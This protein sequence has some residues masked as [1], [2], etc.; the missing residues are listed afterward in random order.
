MGRIPDF[1]IWKKGALRG[2]QNTSADQPQD[3]GAGA[4][5]S[6]DPSERTGVRALVAQMAPALTGGARTNR[7]VSVVAQPVAPPPVMPSGTMPAASPPSVTLPVNPTVAVTEQPDAPPVSLPDVADTSKPSASGAYLTRSEAG[8]APQMAGTRPALQHNPADASQNDAIKDYLSAVSAARLRPEKQD[9][10]SGDRATDLRDRRDALEGYQPQKRSWWD[11]LKAA[12]P[13]SLFAAARTGNPLAAAG[14]LLGGVT[15]GTA[16]RKLADQTWRNRQLAE[17]GAQLQQ[18]YADEQQQSRTRLVDAQADLAEARPGMEQAKADVQAR[19]RAQAAIQREI[20]NR[21]KEPRPFDQNDVYDSSLAQRAQAA[22]VSFDP[23]GFGDT[24]NP[25]T[26]EML[27]PTDPSGTRKTRAVYDRASNTWKPLAVDGQPIATGYAQPVGPDGMTA[28]QRGN[29][30]LG[31]ERL[32]ESKHH[33]QV[34]EGQ[35]AERIGI[36][37]QNFQLG[38]A[39][40]EQGEARLAQ[41]AD[42]QTRT[43]YN[44]LST[45]VQQRNDAQAQA[46]RWRSYKGDD[47]GVQPWAEKRA[48]VFE[49]KIRS[50]EDRM[51]SHYGDLLDEAATSDDGMINGQQKA[52]ENKGL[53]R[54]PKPPARAPQSAPAPAQP[55]G[56][57]SRARFR[58][59]YPQYQSAPDSQVD[60]II[61]GQGYQPKP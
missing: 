3:D 49:D 12:L 8:Q 11:N 41:G 15:V 30:Q 34:T 44:Q 27:D 58:A 33:N 54:T 2:A 36:A 21:L 1:L 48:G 24:K 37:R 45:L 39:R 52:M 56:S 53:M 6:V 25:A 20:G 10:N 22:G 50:L 28:S 57:V 29:L 35:G 26:R 13:P 23:K 51:Q 60:S 46:N 43:R 17:T 42:R 32:E 61:S 38:V 4:S 40:F 31:G 59:K 16:D 19:T 47:G 9:F 55:Q 7:P 14:A 18:E 5:A